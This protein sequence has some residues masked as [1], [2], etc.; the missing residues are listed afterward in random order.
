MPL[1]PE[2]QAMLAELAA[3]DGP[4]IADLSPAEGRE[5][6]RL[7][8][9]LDPEAP[10]V[11]VA[12]R[13]IPGPGGALAVR[14]YT[15]EGPGP[16]PVYVNFHGGGWVIGD[17]DTADTVCRGIATTAG[18]VVVSV[19]YRL[20][21]EHRF[22]AA[23]EDAF[24]ATAWVAGH[25]AEL[26]GNGRL[27][28]GGES[29]G[30]NLAAVVCQQARDRNGPAIDFQLLLYPV[31][32]CDLDRA[33]YRENGNGYLLELNT[34]R[35]FWDH[36]CPDPAERQSP[37]ASPLRAADLSGLPPAL[38]VTAEFDPLRDEGEAY[39]AALA[40]AGT[41][42]EA[43]RY[44]GLVHDFFATARMFPCSRA[45]FDHACEALRTALA[46]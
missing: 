29:A 42:A 14:V 11:Q 24:A 12:D 35:W 8:R 19:D 10:V 45:G 38:V 32:D 16:F 9:P 31:T 2:Y 18:C 15:P 39:A 34:M 36:Y 33:S 28:V 21:P 7:M 4:A 40:A 27:A 6:Y 1:A 46:R 20:A 22:P 23:V 43:I 30:S 37:Q 41:P 3:A 25:M 5:L 26:N 13:S 44:D 17:L